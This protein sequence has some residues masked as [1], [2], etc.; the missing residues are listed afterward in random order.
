MEHKN[1]YDI[2]FSEREINSLSECLSKLN[3]F[4]AAEGDARSNNIFVALCDLQAKIA[5]EI[6]PELKMEPEVFLELAEGY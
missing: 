5:N 2:R 3:T 4:Y 1:F 6:N